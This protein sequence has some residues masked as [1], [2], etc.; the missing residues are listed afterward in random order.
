MLS[1]FLYFATLVA[2]ISALFLVYVGGEKTAAGGRGIGNLLLFSLVFALVIWAFVA[3]SWTMVFAL[4]GFPLGLPWLAMTRAS[5]PL[6]LAVGA[7][8]GVWGGV[9]WARPALRGY[10]TALLGGLVVAGMPGCLALLSG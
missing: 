6:L 10:K 5:L 1:F 3:P 2:A 9:Y 4:Y 8:L 7:V